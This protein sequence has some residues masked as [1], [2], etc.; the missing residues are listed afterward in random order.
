MAGSLNNLANLALAAD[1]RGRPAPEG[2]DAWTLYEESLRLW[3]ELG[4]DL[5]AAGVM[6]DMAVIATRTGRYDDAAGLLTEGAEIYRRL[7]LRRGFANYTT[8]LAGLARRQADYDG[9][10]FALEGLLHLG[11]DAGDRMLEAR[12]L[13]QLADLRWVEGDL[14]DAER[15]Y[16]EAAVIGR[17]LDRSWPLYEALHGLGQLALLRGEVAQ[18]RERFA[19]AAASAQREEPGVPDP[20]SFVSLA[21]AAVADAKPAEA[22]AHCRKAVVI[23]SSEPSRPGPLAI[24]LDVLSILDAQAGHLERAAMFLGAAD[25][26]HARIGPSDFMPYRALP[27]Y[28]RARTVIWAGLGDARFASACAA[29]GAL[30]FDDIIALAEAALE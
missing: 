20:W 9:A 15:I 5:R 24:A 30:T 4:D 27:E 21:N 1:N 28:E 23:C 3:Q 29:G 19:E 2:L 18:A 8:G 12:S 26:L 16:E 11:R 7:G 10:R 13:I 17:S 6:G 25:A 22:A 14:G